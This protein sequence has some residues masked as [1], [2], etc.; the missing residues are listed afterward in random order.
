MA[1][2]TFAAAL[3]AA[4]EANW[5]RELAWLKT[6]VSFPSL[7]GEEARARQLR[8]EGVRIGPVAV[9]RAPVAARKGLAELGDG[10]ADVLMRHGIRIGPGAWW[11]QVAVLA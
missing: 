11:L 2:A 3:S 9:E 7:R 10:G 8:H 6:V 1:D 5:Q 4:V